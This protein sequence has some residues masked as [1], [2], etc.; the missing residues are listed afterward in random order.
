MDEV[1]MAGRGRH[2]S[3]RGYTPSKKLIIACSA[4]GF[5]CLYALYSWS[6]TRS[7]RS[8]VSGGGRLKRYHTWKTQDFVDIP[9]EILDKAKSVQIDE[10][11]L[12]FDFYGQV[13]D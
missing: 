8:V 12:S 5:I 3:P 10:R 11:T 7:A 13:I 9:T 6:G 2:S 1:G 4:L